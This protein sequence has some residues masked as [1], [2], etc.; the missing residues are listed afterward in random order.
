MIPQQ[1]IKAKKWQ[2][3]ERT[4]ADLNRICGEAFRALKIPAEWKFKEY[5][6]TMLNM[7]EPGEIQS[8]TAVF[9]NTNTRGF[10]L[11]HYQIN[12]HTYSERLSLSEV[13]FKNF[14]KPCYICLISNK[15]PQQMNAFF[16]TIS[17]I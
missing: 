17:N 11:K 13:S 7:E 16:E 1:T 8:I 5:E 4:D 15:S 14:G 10:E 3:P 12:F 2:R 9:I 6:R